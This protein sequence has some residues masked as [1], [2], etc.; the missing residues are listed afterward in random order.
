MMKLPNGVQ[1]SVSGSTITMKGPKGSCAMRFPTDDLKIEQKDGE[2]TVIGQKMIANTFNAHIANMA[3]GV[4]EGHSHS[5]KVIYSHFPIAMEIKGK[6]IL[7]KNFLGEKQPRHAKII[8]DTKVEV[9]G[10]AMTISGPSKNDVGQTVANLRT[11]TKI[12]KLD[13]RVFQDGVYP[14]IE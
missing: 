12:R 14:V 1:L 7:V 6:E 11:A 2:V 8:G 4:T 5:L 13:S 9:K 3:K 10:Q